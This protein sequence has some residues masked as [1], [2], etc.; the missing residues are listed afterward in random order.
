MKIGATISTTAHVAILLWGAYSFQGVKTFEVAAVEALPVDF[1][2]I[3]SITRSIEGDTK[4]KRAEKPAPKPTKKPPTP[5][6]AENAG[7]TKLDVKSKVEAEAKKEPVNVAAPP[8]EAKQPDP[9]PEKITKPEP[10]KAD[11]ET[12][13]PTTDVASLN[14]PPQPV[15][16]ETKK[17]PP[18]KADEGEQ[19]AKLPDVAP[20]PVS[21]P[22]PPEAKSAKT[23]DRKK[24]DE[25][26]KKKTSAKGKKSDTTEDQ[27][28]ALL[29]KQKP[30]ASGKKRS[31]KPAS[32]G[33]RTS[34][35]ANKLSR[36]EMDGLMDAIARC[37]SGIAGREISENLEVKVTMDLA[38]DG[39]IIGNPI[40]EASGGT[41]EERRRFSRE[42]L[43]YVKRCA[44]YDFLPKEKYETWSKVIPTFHP[45]QMFQ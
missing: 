44:P 29:N 15:K 7:D 39:N 38:Q 2:P 35:G 28:A 32:L 9:E 19:F 16:E 26:K 41:S 45:S 22:K 4:A 24:P 3:E 34:N 27:I 31:A 11:K 30:S 37:S 5:E 40:A 13:V 21:R 14:E 20:L 36:S 18:A 1:I 33:S 8:P 6:P 43:R 12:P 25:V 17:E 23:K 10:A 42:V